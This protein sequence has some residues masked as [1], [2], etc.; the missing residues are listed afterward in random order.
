MKYVYL[1]SYFLETKDKWVTITNTEFDLLVPHRNILARG[2]LPDS[3]EIE[4]LFESIMKSPSV[5]SRPKEING[6]TD[7]IEIALV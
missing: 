6:I 2:H 7:Y 5:D 4:Q 1:K 3:E